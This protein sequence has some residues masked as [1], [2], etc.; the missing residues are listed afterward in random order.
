MVR[1]ASLALTARLALEGRERRVLVVMG[2]LGAALLY[3]D[4][5]I[6]PAISVLSALEGLKQPMPGCRALHPANR[7]V[8]VARFVLPATPG[9]E[10]DRPTVSGRS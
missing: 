3:G 5:A 2:I 7:G 4:G 9:H 8:G 6:T 1:G 10:R